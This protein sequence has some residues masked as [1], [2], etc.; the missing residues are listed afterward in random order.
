MRLTV[1]F[2]LD[3]RFTISEHGGVITPSELQARA[4]I[5]KGYASDLLAGNKKPAPLTAVR[6]FRATGLRLGP[7]EGLTDEEIAVV[8]KAHG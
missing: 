8:E 5:S 7:L 2:A 3:E 6:I 4:G 1:N